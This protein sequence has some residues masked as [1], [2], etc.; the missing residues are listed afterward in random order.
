MDLVEDEVGKASGFTCPELAE[1]NHQPPGPEPGG[2]RYQRLCPI[3]CPTLGSKLASLERMRR[4]AKAPVT[5][6]GFERA[7]VAQNAPRRA[8]EARRAIHFDCVSIFRLKK[9]QTARRV[10]RSGVGSGVGWV[11]VSLRPSA[12]RCAEQ[13]LQTCINTGD[14][15]FSAFSCASLRNA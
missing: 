14:F 8:K 9:D 11:F 4:D 13:T 10:R 6:Q 15:R 5:E 7:A 1:G 2:Y 3:L 12:R